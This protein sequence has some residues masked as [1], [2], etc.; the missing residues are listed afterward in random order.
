MPNTGYDAV[1]STGR[2][3]SV[4]AVLMSEDKH[5]DGT[6]R[7]ELIANSRDLQRNYTIAGWACRKH[8]DFV[9]SFTFKAQTGNT[10]LDARLEDLMTWWGRPHNCD[11]GRRHPLKR[12]VRLA[13]ARAVIDGDIGLLKL[14]A[15]QL[16]PIEG[17]RIRSPRGLVED[18][19]REVQGVR[20]DKTGGAL[21]YALHNRRRYNGFEF[22]R[23]IPASRMIQHGYFERF[24]QT[25]GISP[26]ASALNQFRD[27]YEN[28]D[29]ALAKA[30]VAQMFGLKLT[31]NAEESAGY[32]ETGTTESGNT[33][34][35]VDF[36]K[37]PVLL[38]MEPG[39]D[40]EFLENKTPPTEFK[41]FTLAV[42]S[43]ALKALDIPYCFYDESHTNFF[44][45]KAALS[46]Y[47]KACE[48]KQD[49]LRELLRKV[50]VWKMQQWIL[51]G[52]LELPAEMTIADIHFEW[53]AAG[54]P[55]WDMS[56]E[57]E[58]DLKAIDGC[59]TTYTDVC[60][61][62]GL[63]DWKKIVDRRA[64]E[65]AY[66]AEKGVT[67]GQ[68]AAALSTAVADQPADEDADDDE[69]QAA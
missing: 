37:G 67:P 32:I 63:A 26:L 28:W 38:D 19:D 43:A 20:I 34:Y 10:D 40:A 7:R 55:W 49:N 36:G 39:D 61:A 2:R 46:L 16:Q 58:G 41:E 69:E 1:E 27:V 3:R 51:S 21:A 56:K 53:I 68:M 45:S 44:G 42:I 23:W 15:G 13:E 5:L 62:R 6:K 24:D 25:R 17:D 60:K 48:P 50:T 52:L 14:A 47:L 31:R 9:S 64:E 4:V 65:N 30:K 8:L 11:A 33:V 18:S 59:L 35:D 66:L 22:D 12:L 57:V 54:L 29:Y